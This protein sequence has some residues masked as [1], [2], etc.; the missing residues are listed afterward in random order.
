MMWHVCMMMWHMCTLWRVTNFS[1][2]YRGLAVTNDNSRFMLYSVNFCEFLWISCAFYFLYTKKCAEFTEGFRWRTNT[3]NLPRIHKKKNS[4]IQKM[5]REFTRVHKT[6]QKITQLH[7]K[8]LGN[9]QK[10]TKIHRAKDPCIVF[11]T[12]VQKFTEIHK[13]HTNSQG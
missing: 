11:F 9:S 7:K 1:D 5:C 2:L 6:S 3:K 13:T 12:H 4:R 8:I 10:F